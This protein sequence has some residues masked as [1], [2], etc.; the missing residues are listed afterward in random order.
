MS[1]ALQTQPETPERTFARDLRN[2]FDR[3]ISNHHRPEDVI[4]AIVEAAERLAD[5]KD[6]ERHV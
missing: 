4:R 6:R 1:D 2:A 3:A 5:A